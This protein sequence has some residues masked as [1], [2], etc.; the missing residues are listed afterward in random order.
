MGSIVLCL[1]LFPQSR[2]FNSFQ[3][4]FHCFGFHC[5]YPSL[6]LD[7]TALSGNTV[8]VVM[9]S[10][11]SSFKTQQTEIV[12]WLSGFSSKCAFKRE[13][14]VNQGMQGKTL[15]KTLTGENVSGA[16]P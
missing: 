8:V 16:S 1:K 11:R 6:L 7:W 5:D 3:K 9:L 12:F 2:H 4:S 14:E 10:I 15:R 13:R